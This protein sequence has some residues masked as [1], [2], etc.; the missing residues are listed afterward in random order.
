MRGIA[1]CA[2]Y[3]SDGAMDLRKLLGIYLRTAAAIVLRPA[4]ASVLAA[5]PKSASQYESFAMTHSG[6][7]ARGKALFADEHRL[8]CARCHRVSG[9]GAPGTAQVGPDLSA[10]GDT[11]GRTDLVQAIVAPSASIAEGYGTMIVET[12]SEEIVDGI[13]KEATDAGVGL[14]D[15]EGRLVRI[16]A[17][18][19][20]ERRMSTVSMMPQGLQNA[21]TLGEFTDL[22]EYLGSL[23]APET[24][25][26]ESNGMPATIAGLKK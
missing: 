2:V 3:T 8:A 19:I 12:A 16:A 11:L 20:R 13:V 7:A 6:D 14:L 24:A 17:A 22:I 4:A 21:L 9:A 10:I 5:A 23:R 18:D 1:I 25:A 26:A 15:V